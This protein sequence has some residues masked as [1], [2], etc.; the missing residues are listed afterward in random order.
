MNRAKTTEEARKK[1]ISDIEQLWA[2][3]APMKE[4]VG[5]YIFPTIVE[6]YNRLEKAEKRIAELESQNKDG[7]T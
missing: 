4:V 6:L 5:R 7:A 3:D 1:F 2:A